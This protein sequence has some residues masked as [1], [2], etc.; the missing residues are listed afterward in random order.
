MVVNMLQD[1]SQGVR[2]LH[3]CDPQVIH[4]DL[5]AQ[6][7]LVDDRFRAKV[8]DF[9]FSHGRAKRQAGGTGT[10]YWMAPEL[11]RGECQNNTK[12]DVYSFGMILFEVYSK[13]IPYDNEDPTEVL[14]LVADSAVRKRPPVPKDCPMAIKTLMKDCLHHE[15]GARPLFDEISSRLER[16]DRRELVKARA[17]HNA[18]QGLP[19]H[20]AQQLRQG[21]KVQPET[22]KNVSIAVLQV[23]ELSALQTADSRKAAD[24]VSRLHE[25]LSKLAQEHG[26]F[27]LDTV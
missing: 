8:A 12:T 20:V 9:G 13:C 10:L 11:L 7:I 27:K 5:K 4:G 21:K 25:T 22:K 16:I 6:N 23:A 26:L 15:A 3:C 24:A 2:F 1:I 19:E 17:A 18:F 14:R